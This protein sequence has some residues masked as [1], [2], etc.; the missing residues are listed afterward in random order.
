MAGL[1]GLEREMGCTREEFLRLLPAATALAPVRT[2][3]DELVL[4]VGAGEV[5]I[6]LAERPMRRIA[7]VALPVLAVRFRFAGLG[8]EA[9]R[10]FLD[11]FDRYTQRGGG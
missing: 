11:R 3:G 5:R 2:E 4:S 7:L 1:F 10:A 8:E 6:H 9:Q